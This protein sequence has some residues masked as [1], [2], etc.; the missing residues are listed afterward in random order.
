[1]DNVE[2]NALMTIKGRNI[3][4]TKRSFNVQCDFFHMKGHTRAECYKIIGY[5]TNF[6]PKK[7]YGGNAANNVIVN[8]NRKHDTHG[9]SSVN[10]AGNDDITVFLV[11]SSNKEWIID[12]G[13]T[14]H[15][16]SDMNLLDNTVKISDPKEKKELYSGKVRRIGKEIGGLYLLTQ[17][18]AKGSTAEITSLI[19]SKEKQD[20]K[21][22][23]TRLGHAS[24]KTLSQL[25]HF[26][27]SSCKSQLEQCIVYPLDTSG[28][29]SHTV[30]AELMKSSAYYILMYGGHIMYKP[31]MNQ[32][33]RIIKA[34]RSDNEGEFLHSECSAFFQNHGIKHQRTCVYTP[35]QNGIAEGKNRHILEGCCFREKIFPFKNRKQ[36]QYHLFL[37]LENPGDMLYDVEVPIEEVADA[38]SPLSEAMP[39]ADQPSPAAELDVQE[40]M[41]TQDNESHISQEATLPSA[42]PPSIPPMEPLRRSERDKKNPVWMSDYITVTTTVTMQN[43]LTYARLKPHYQLYLAALTSISEQTIFSEASQD[44]RWVEEMRAEIQALEENKTWEVVQLPPEKSP[45]GLKWVFKVKYKANGDVERFKARLVSKGY[46]HHE[47][48]DYQET[49]SHVVKIV[50]VRTVISIATAEGWLLHQ[51]DIYNAF[52]QCDLY[53]EVYMKLPEGFA[54][55]GE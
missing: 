23:H 5:P 45:I 39:T 21:L 6:K 1:M 34:F 47:G 32:F 15:M 36:S 3:Q 43:Y 14:D 4:Q 55:Q 12:M 33:N 2:M 40:A 53:E 8:D 44:P 11:E 25:F 37:E 48:I 42:P 52:L 35:Q 46:N 38:S 16:N 19:A 54:S 13:A 10:M 7:K 9:S 49:F 20:I 31:L 50:T 29:S 27:Q 26:S 41:P 30:L 28:C 22:W 24:I 17:A 51:M 18:Y